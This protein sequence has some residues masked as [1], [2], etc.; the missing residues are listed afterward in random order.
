MALNNQKPF[1]NWIRGKLPVFGLWTLIGLSFALSAYY[2]DIAE[3]SPISWKRAL[4]YS[5][6]NYYTWMVLSPLIAIL[7]RR[8]PLKKNYWVQSIIVHLP[9]SAVFSAIQV[10]AYMSLYLL[11]DP[12]PAGFSATLKQVLGTT[13]IFRFHYGILA[14]WAILAVTTA[15]KERTNAA[16]LQA[17]LAQAELQALRMQ[18]HPHFL[19]NTLHSI[20]ALVV[21]DPVL[22]KRMISH[23][24]DF[25]R[26]TL[27]SS[28]AQSVPFSVE[29]EFLKRY[30]A[31][32]QVRFQDRLKIAMDIEPQTLNAQIPNLILQP[33]VENAIRHGIAP[34]LAAGQIEIRAR[35]LN[36]SL[37]VEIE[38]DGVGLPE[39]A[40]ST[41]ATQGVGLSNTRARLE[42]LYGANYRFDL[43][44]TVDGGVVVTILIPFEDGGDTQTI[45][46]GAGK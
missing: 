37:Q 43:S 20:S 1:L 7:A 26:M 23:L 25:L 45:G 13:F 5:F 38:D 29:L 15:M 14:Y 22:A 10:V 21:E 40:K 27:E 24:G 46:N 35:R 31:I 2:N 33:I 19:F 42:Q 3:G 16:R 34:R 39:V 36:G 9:A 28:G 44:N 12:Q 8:F 17:Q 30:L 11:I 32:E 4:T 41:G 18:L 6:T